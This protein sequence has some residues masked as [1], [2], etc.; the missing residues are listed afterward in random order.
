MCAS[1]TSTS[2][3]NPP[4]CRHLNSLRYPQPHARGDTTE[5]S[6]V[7]MALRPAIRKSIAWVRPAV[8]PLIDSNLTLALATPRQRQKRRIDS[9]VSD[10]ELPP[11]V[12]KRTVPAKMRKRWIYQTIQEAA[13]GS[14]H[15]EEAP[16]MEEEHMDIDNGNLRPSFTSGTNSYFLPDSAIVP[17]STIMPPPPVPRRRKSKKTKKPPTSTSPLSVPSPSTHFAKLSLLSP[18]VEVSKSLLDVAPY[19]FHNRPPSPTPSSPSPTTPTIKLRT[20]PI[21]PLPVFTS[22]PPSQQS[23]EPLRYWTD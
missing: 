8:F 19:S 11:V 12:N 17:D 23:Q 13:P 7:Q 18:T 15:S 22:L 21:S 2:N 14:T 10:P 20:T 1:S 16:G 9:K 3:H 5:R 6:A 4:L